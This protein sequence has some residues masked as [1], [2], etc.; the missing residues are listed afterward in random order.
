[1]DGDEERV[2]TEQGW[3]GRYGQCNN[4]AL[5]ILHCVKEEVQEGSGPANIW[6]IQKIQQTPLRPPNRTGVK[7]G[8]RDSPVSITH[9][10]HF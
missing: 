10:S 2:C 1:M 5:I 6:N 3:S 4:V 9:W 8:D 7:R